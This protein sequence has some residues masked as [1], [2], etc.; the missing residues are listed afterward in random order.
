LT[1]GTTGQV[2]AGNGA[3]CNPG[4]AF[5]GDPDTGLSGP[6]S[7]VLGFISG[8]DERLRLVN[9]LLALEETANAN[10]NRGITINQADQDNFA[11]ALKSSD[12]ATGF[13]GNFLGLETDDFFTIS[14]SSGTLGG[15]TMAMLG[16]DGAM[17]INWNVFA[18]GGTAETADG[19]GN[20]GLVTF[21]IGEHDGSNTRAAP[22]SNSNLFVIREY[23]TSFAT[24]LILKSDDGELHL[25]NTTLQS[26]DGECDAQAV[27]ALQRTNHNGRGMIDSRWEQPIY[28]HATLQEMGVV[29]EKDE[30]GQFLIRVQP[31]LALHDGAIWQLY[32]SMQ[33]Q[34]EEITAL[35]SRLHALTGGK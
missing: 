14:K 31:Y 24:R 15:V 21:N 8:G 4:F 10:M 25:G 28:N 19:T 11:F 16:E 12:I 22:A 34:Q 26:L 1:L 3:A 23:G 33:D 9:G 17:A 7:D 18:M 35:K 2:F 13:A 29:G 5:Q 32:T 27:R 30:N 20:V 6:G